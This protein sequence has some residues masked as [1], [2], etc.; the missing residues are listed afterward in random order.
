MIPLPSLFPSTRAKESPTSHSPFKSSTTST[1]KADTTIS[2]H[3]VLLSKPTFLQ[4]CVGVA[5]RVSA[6]HPRESALVKMAMPALSAPS[7]KLNSNNN[8]LKSPHRSI[9]SNPLWEPRLPTQRHSLNSVT[10]LPR[11]APSLLPLLSRPAPSSNRSS[12][13]TPLKPN[14]MRPF[15]SNPISFPSPSPQTKKAS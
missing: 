11:K 4:T 10:S 12:A 9:K 8:R 15:R 7:L 13:P 1:D 6:I 3:S 14:S 2:P 5:W